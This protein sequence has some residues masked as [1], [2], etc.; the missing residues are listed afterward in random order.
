ME[1]GS[2]VTRRFYFILFLMLLTVSCVSSALGETMYV[3]TQDG[4]PLNVRSK[5]IISVDTLLGCISNHSAVDVISID[6]DGWAKI[7]Y[8]KSDGSV[9]NAYVSCR[10]LS[11]DKE[12]YYR[13]KQANVPTPTAVPVENTNRDVSIDDLNAELKTA[14]N[15]AV[16]F[17][18]LVRPT[19]ASG[20]VNLRWAPNNKVRAILSYPAN[21]KLTVFGETANWYQVRDPEQGNTGFIS[22]KL[23]MVVPENLEE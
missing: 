21:K 5:P 11:Y 7:R 4:D 2:T 1:G 3:S 14:K 16:P 6:E 22:K 18:V 12:G 10:Y 17:T 9:I 8:E 13:S 15:V 19:R 20:R 23:V